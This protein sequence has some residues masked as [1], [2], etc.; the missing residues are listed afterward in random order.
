MSTS[1]VRENRS[2]NISE[3]DV[4][5]Q[6]G[7]ACHSTGGSFGLHSMISNN[8]AEYDSNLDMISVYEDVKL[9]NNEVKYSSSDAGYESSKSEDAKSDELMKEEFYEFEHQDG[10]PD[11]PTPSIFTL[12][13]YFVISEKILSS[14]DPYLEDIIKTVSIVYD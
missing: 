10:S 1:V 9:P 4:K 12:R 7:D 14:L 5:W 11:K 3:H 6:R 13:P 8:E 2:L